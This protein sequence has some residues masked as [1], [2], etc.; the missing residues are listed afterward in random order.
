MAINTEDKKMTYKQNIEK[1][2]NGELKSR[3]APRNKQSKG[4]GHKESTLPKN[5]LIT[6]LIKYLKRAA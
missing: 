5:K 3:L 4:K 6:K 2:I 1:T